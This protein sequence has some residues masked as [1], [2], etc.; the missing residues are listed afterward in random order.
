M[1]ALA[2]IVGVLGVGAGIW[3]AD[4]ATALFISLSVIKDGYK[5]LS[6]A[7][8]DLMDRHPVHVADKTKDDLLDKITNE[9]KQWVWVEDAV[10]RFREHGQVY[11]GEIYVVVIDDDI[12]SSEIEQA[13]EKI[14]DFHWKIH[15]VTIMPVRS[16]L[17]YDYTK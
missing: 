10:V 7:I 4:S 9:V 13:L 14:K 3:W 15:D 16:L 2:A 6:E 8:K 5:N 17:P 12:S 1:T 11:F